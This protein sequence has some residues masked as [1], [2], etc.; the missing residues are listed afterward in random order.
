M[1]AAAA[2]AVTEGLAPGLRTRAFVFNTLL[3]DKAT[4]DRLRSYPGWIASRNLDNEASD[5]S[6]QA[7]VDAVVSRYV[8]AGIKIAATATLDSV[9]VLAFGRQSR[10]VPVADRGCVSPEKLGQGRE[11]P[12]SSRFFALEPHRQP[13]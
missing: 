6:V 10:E 7:L 8:S 13:I 3:A 12:R 2:A 1:R 5:E 9:G 11:M 4:D